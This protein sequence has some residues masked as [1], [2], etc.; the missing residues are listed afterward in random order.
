MTALFFMFFI[1]FGYVLFCIYK[2]P[3]VLDMIK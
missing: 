3:Y 1:L 2:W